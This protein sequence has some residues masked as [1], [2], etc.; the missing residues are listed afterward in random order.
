M[1]NGEIF[2]VTVIGSGPGG[3]VA[4]V[5]ASQMGLKAA[6]VERDP[7]GPGGTC[8]LRGCIPTKA[9]LHTADLYED[10]LNRKEFGITADNVALDFP[11]VMGRKDRIV[12]RLSKG[13]ETY[14]FKKNKITLFKGHGRLEGAQ[15]G[16]GQVGRGRDEGQHQERA[17]RDG[18]E[19]EEPA[20][21]GARRQADPHLRRHAAAQ[22][23]PE[24]PDRDRRRGGGDGVRVGLRPLRLERDGARDAAADPAARGRGDLGRGAQGARQADDDPRGRA[25]RGG[26]QDAERR[27]GRL[28][29]GAGRVE[30]RDGRRAAGRGGPRSRHGRAE[31]RVDEGR[32]STAATSRPTT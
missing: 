9:L 7:G 3:Y 23:D 4:A 17:D 19:A 27:R 1:A 6:V 10:F 5:R 20:R 8:L 13:I 29:H 22:G 25:H 16:R 21:D 24:D 2:D 11:A 31:P 15:D 30:D 32:S 18:L 14:L 28:P 26:A 12:N